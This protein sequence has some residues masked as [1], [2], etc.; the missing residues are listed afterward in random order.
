MYNDLQISYILSLCFFVTLS[1]IKKIDS[2]WTVHVVQQYTNGL[3][4]HPILQILQGIHVHPDP[5]PWHNYSCAITAMLANF[6][7]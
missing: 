7:G 5:Y 1:C 6:E 3:N 2:M 4:P